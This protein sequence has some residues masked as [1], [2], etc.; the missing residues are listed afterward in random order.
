MTQNRNTLAAL[1]SGR[2][3]YLQAADQ[4]LAGPK[5]PSAKTWHNPRESTR[6]TDKDRHRAQ[7][8]LQC[9]WGI[10][11]TSWWLPGPPAEEMPKWFFQ[12]SFLRLAT[13][14]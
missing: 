10:G 8:G 14:F 5:Y 6:L 9:L 4:D 12:L 3:S 13:L 2:T 11:A 1:C 7:R